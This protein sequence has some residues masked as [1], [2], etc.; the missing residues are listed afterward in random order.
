MVTTSKGGMPPKFVPQPDFIDTNS[1]MTYFKEM[2]QLKATG[3]STG[4]ITKK[5]SEFRPKEN[6]KRDAMVVFIYRALGSPAFT[7]PKKSP[8][9]DVKTNFVFYKEITWAASKGITTGWKTKKGDEFRPFANVQR[10][11]VMAFLFRAT[12]N[13]KTYKA[14]VKSPFIDVKTNFVFY[15]EIN[16]AYA[17]G[18]AVH[19]KTSKGNEFRPFGLV[20]R[21]AMASFVIEWLR[22]LRNSKTKPVGNAT[23]KV[24]KALASNLSGSITFNNLVAKKFCIAPS[25]ALL[26]D[27]NNKGWENWLKNQMSMTESVDQKWLSTYSDKWLPMINLPSYEAAANYQKKTGMQLTGVG[28][29]AATRQREG[30]T[31]LRHIY[32]TRQVNEAW[33]SFWLDHFSV[34]YSETGQNQTLNIDLWMRDKAMTSFPEILNAMLRTLKLYQF[35]DAD[36]SKKGKTNE[37]LARELLELYTV[38]IT[39][40]IEEDIRQLA[41]FLTGFSWSWDGLNNLAFF[42][43]DHDSSIKTVKVLGRTYKNDVD[44]INVWAVLD[45]LAHDLAWDSRTIKFISTKICAHFIQDNPT[46]SMVNAVIKT[47]KESGGNIKEI[48]ITM[49]LH[50]DFSNS[51]GAKWR[52]PQ[53]MMATHQANLGPVQNLEPHLK[54]HPYYATYKC[55]EEYLARLGQAGHYPRDNHSPKGYDNRAKTW[56]NASSILHT[57]NALHESGSFAPRTYKT[58]KTFLDTLGYKDSDYKNTAKKLLMETTGFI[59]DE[60]VHDQIT[61]ILSDK[62]MS[63]TDR[64]NLAVSRSYSSPYGFIA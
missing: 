48:M 10:D 12:A 4:W 60:I 26:R 53:E 24:S 20:T 43:S 15:K 30:A 42:P 41:K 57:I 44:H 64:V 58:T 36:D 59:P 32:S 21:E 16:W 52:R 18:I 62:S 39:T 13:N 6:V 56:M 2:N 46:N 3:V 45:K 35:L 51:A 1:K 61:K 40:G 47:Y 19:Y 63:W 17:N 34:P 22:V 33:T 31:L 29:D 5:G 50:P 9:I 7:P 49:I 8:F 14:P 54:A 25:V 38:G 27:I 37:N 55:C 11:A 28:V 23:Y